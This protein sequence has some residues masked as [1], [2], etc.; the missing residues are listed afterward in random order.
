MMER[1]E[2]AIYQF[3]FTCQINIYR[4][5]SWKKVEIERLENNHMIIFFLEY[6]RVF[7][8]F[9]ENGSLRNK[10][11]CNNIDNDKPGTAQIGAYGS[12]YR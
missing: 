1:Q 4:I 2:F 11:V 7:C 6:C 8:H 3:T 12:K 10:I 9:C 5:C